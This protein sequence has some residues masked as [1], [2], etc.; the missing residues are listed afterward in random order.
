MEGARKIVGWGIGGSRVG[1]EV[2]IYGLGFD[3]GGRLGVG[4]GGWG[5]EF[6]GRGMEVLVLG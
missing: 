2:W 6:G 3:G 5:V 4:I 1:T